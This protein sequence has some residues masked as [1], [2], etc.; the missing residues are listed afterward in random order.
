VTPRYAAQ[1]G[2]L[3]EDMPMVEPKLSAIQRDILRLLAAAG[4][5]GLTLWD[6]KQRLYTVRESLL[7]RSVLNLQDNGLVRV[8]DWTRGDL[9]KRTFRVHLTVEGQ[10]LVAKHKLS[11]QPAMSSRVG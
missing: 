8:A 5:A 7:E 6:I 4:E 9:E 3:P 10:H 2:K 11:A 1:L